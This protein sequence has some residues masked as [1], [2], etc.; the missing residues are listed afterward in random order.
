[1]AS[2]IKEEQIEEY[3]E[4]LKEQILTAHR[5]GKDIKLGTKPHMDTI[6]GGTS[7]A[8]REIGETTYIQI[9]NCPD[10]EFER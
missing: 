1:M 2:L 10:I 5:A 9:G 4:G 8:H 3:I 6:Y 7:A